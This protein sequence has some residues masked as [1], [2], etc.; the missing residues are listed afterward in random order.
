VTQLALSGKLRLDLRQELAE[1]F[2][3][4]GVGLA[5]QINV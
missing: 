3:F 4:R 5:V 2:Q 1:T